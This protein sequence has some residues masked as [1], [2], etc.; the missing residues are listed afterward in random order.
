MYEE[1]SLSQTIVIPSTSTELTFDFELPACDSVADYLELRIDGNTVFTVNGADPACGTVGYTRKSVDVTAYADD[2]PHTIQFYSESF[3]D[4]RKNTNFFVDNIV[5]PGVPSLCT[6]IPGPRF[7]SDPAPAST[8]AFGN[9][10]ILTESSPY[11]IQVENP[12]IEALDLSC[13]ITGPGADQFNL[14][15]CPSPVPV[16][17]LAEVG[18]SCEP[19]S[20]GLKGASLDITTNDEAQPV[21]SFPLTCTGVSVP[22]QVIT[23]SP[24]IQVLPATDP[25]SIDVSYSTS[26]GDDTLSGLELRIHW[27]STQ[28]VFGGLTSVWVT[29]LVSTDVACQ[30][31]AANYD[32]D[33][34]TDCYATVLWSSGGNTFPGEG[35]TPTLLFTANFTGDLSPAAST[36][37]NFSAG[38]LAPGYS[39]KATSAIVEEETIGPQTLFSDGFE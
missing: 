3:A 31:D 33:A 38:Q 39:L 36:R 27:D 22:R 8:I 12:G 18:V 15:T 1:A 28:L 20:T 24:V 4:N 26:I 10:V 34:S 14:L 11:L 23:P 9:Q 19:G 13:S 7:Q 16:S 5:I 2:S 35:N 30:A 32:N 37:L 6:V 17:G 21:V 29:D 25:I